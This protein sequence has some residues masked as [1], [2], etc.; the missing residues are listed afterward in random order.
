M[1]RNRWHRSA[2]CPPAIVQSLVDEDHCIEQFPR[3]TMKRLFVAGAPVS[4]PI[5]WDE[6]DDPK[7][8]P[9]A[10][11]IRNIDK[12]LARVGD[13]FRAMLAAAQPFAKLA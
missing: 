1:I 3:F 13:P 10:F 12:R 8:K 6:L 2:R 4:T 9:D 11:T 5:E 7:L